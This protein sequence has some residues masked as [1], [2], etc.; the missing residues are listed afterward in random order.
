MDIV[1]L[2]RLTLDP[3]E[4]FDLTGKATFHLL[5]LD[6][7]HPV[8]SGNKWFKLRLN[9]KKALARECSSLITFGGPFSN[10][11]VATAFAARANSLGSMAIVRGFPDLEPTPTLAQCAELGMQLHFVSHEA[12]R[13]KDKSDYLAQLQQKHPGAYIIHEGGHNEEGIA[14]TAAISA[15]IPAWATCIATSV[16]S[17]TTFLGL[18]RNLQPHQHL[19]GF[20]PLKGG[21]YLE[22]EFQAETPLTNPRCSIIDDFHFGGFGKANQVLVDFM[23]S[24]YHQYH[25]PL[26]S[27][28]TAKMLYGLRQLCSEGFFPPGSE[29]VVV[30]SGGLQGN[31]SLAGKLVY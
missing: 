12:Y 29:V 23:N 8:V 5:R 31:A 4:D 25:I 21:K 27:V 17:G 13:Q 7:I 14:G 20:A 9:M 30:H 26:D 11:L 16:G 3:L 24:F 2:S 15:Y 6:A 10:H 22:A 1:D 28:Y 18:K 19:L